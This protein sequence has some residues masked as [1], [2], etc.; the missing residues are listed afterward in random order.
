MNKQ[1]HLAHHTESEKFVFL[2]KE[3]TKVLQ[4]D[5]GKTIKSQVRSG[6]EDV[7]EDLNTQ[8][9]Q[10]TKYCLPI[11]D[12]QNT[13][14]EGEQPLVSKVAIEEPAPLNTDAKVNE[15]KSLI[16]HQSEEKN[17]AEKIDV[18]DSSESDEL[19]SYSILPEGVILKKS[20][21]EFTDKLF[22]A[23]SIKYSLEPPKEP[24]PP[25]DPSKGKGVATDDSQLQLTTLLEKGGSAQKTLDLKE[26][27]SQGIKIT[28]E[29]TTAQMKEIQRL[30]N[31]RKEEEE[32]E[33]ILKEKLT[34]A[35]YKAQALKWQ[36]HE[37]K[38]AKMIEE[39]NS[40]FIRTYPL[41]ITK[42][43]YTIDSHKILTMRI[44]R[45]NDPLNLIVFSN[46]RLKM[47]RFGEW[48]EVHALSS[49]KT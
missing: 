24:T 23:A 31:L 37:A 21:K 5:M 40:I 36:E 46:F 26:F 15:E 19:N 30:E 49:K 11:Q 47:L 20:V 43:S 35:T 14:Q 10:L 42:I 33:K 12:M 38:K 28:I 1:F 29:E 3:L 32:S 18:E 25:R 34:P 6:I 9:K 48:I 22:K 41:C 39:Y 8:K 16:L 17:E 4:S 45:D 7:R 13:L 44:T 27:N 2:Q